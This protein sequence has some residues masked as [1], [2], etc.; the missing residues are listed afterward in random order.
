MGFRIVRVI[1]QTLAL[2]FRLQIYNRT[3]TTAF[4]TV[5][6]VIFSVG[7]FDLEG[8]LTCYFWSNPGVIVGLRREGMY[9]LF[10]HTVV[11]VV[12]LGPC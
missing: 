1:L 2:I 4:A 3:A 11:A 12:R 10:D 8:D 5:R 6:I 9:K 7:I